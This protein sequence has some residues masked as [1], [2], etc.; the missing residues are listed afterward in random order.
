MM[1]SEELRKVKKEKESI[2]KDYHALQLKHKETEEDYE[3]K[4]SDLI[5]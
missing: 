3:R 5:S 4:V 1:L 2:D